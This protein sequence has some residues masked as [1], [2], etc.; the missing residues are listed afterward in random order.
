MKNMVTLSVFS[1]QLEM[2]SSD[3]SSYTDITVINFQINSLLSN[4]ETD[5][6]CLNATVNF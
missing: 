3:K 5:M 2:K 4:N 1:F 6:R